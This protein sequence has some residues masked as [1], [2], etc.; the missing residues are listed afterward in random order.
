MYSAFSGAPYG[1]PPG[2]VDGDETQQRVEALRANLRDAAVQHRDALVGAATRA[3][4]EYSEHFDGLRG[5]LDGLAAAVSE[6]YGS[7][8]MTQH[9][10]AVQGA[11]NAWGGALPADPDHPEHLQLAFPLAHLL[12]DSR[13][14]QD[15]V[16]ATLAAVQA[17][18]EI[19]RPEAAA[20]AAAATTDAVPQQDGA[21]SRSPG[22]P[23]SQSTDTARED[24]P[25]AP[26]GTT[27]DAPAP[28]NPEG[29]ATP[30]GDGPAPDAAVDAIRQPLE[31]ALRADQP[32]PAAPEPGDLPLWTGPETSPANT[33]ATEPPAGPMDV[34]AQ[35]QAVLDA[36]DEH[37]PSAN[38]TAQDLVAEVDAD[39]ATLQRAF[40][41]AVT[42]AAP[43]E[44]STATT[45]ADTTTEGTAAAPVP[46]QADAV[47]SALQ[48]A[49]THAAALQNLPEWQRIQTVGGAF[50]HLFRV[51]K[52]RAG[53][54]FDRL[55]G[56]HRVGNFFRKASIGVCEKVAQWAQAG[57]DRLR[58]RGE[59][60]GADAP[61]ADALQDVA[62]A[63]AAYSSPGPGR[64]GPPP[65]S[66]NESVTVDIPEM[67]KLGAALARPL[68]G[69]KNGRGSGVSTSAAR[70]RSTTRQGGGKKSGGATGQA[71][72]LRRDGN[73]PQPT[74]KPT[75]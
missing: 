44:P 57:A 75:K 4:S 56:D 20:A 28:E 9:L 69:A 67:R 26:A 37:V 31:D 29:T 10:A 71:G 11:V 30:E 12:Y 68:P 45:P 18:Q 5:A 65:T 38:G 49:D 53:E 34:R 21:E 39:L 60:K 40:A 27:A 23:D 35:F 25:T 48:Q 36:W 63:A 15:Q 72:H 6:G 8:Q 7:Q 51:M 33:A 14:M 1:S 54:H 43:A 59:G 3:Q 50:G 24:A 13:R 70:G 66:S 74:R 62:D 73:E 61:A 58:R 52:E 19:A 64:S 17:E 55:L 46:Q 2:A 32:E 16:R 42:P 47:N 41:E 22:V